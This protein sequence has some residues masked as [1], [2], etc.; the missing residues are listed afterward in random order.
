VRTDAAESELA[1]IESG[2]ERVNVLEEECERARNAYDEVAAQLARKRKAAAKKLV[3]ATETHLHDL[4]LGGAKLLVTLQTQEP[5][6]HGS[7]SVRML[8]AANRG[9]EAV[10]L[11]KGASGGELSRVNLALLLAGSTARGTWIFDEVDAGIGGATAHVVAAKLKALSAHTQVIVVTHLAQIAVQAD[12]HLVVRKDDEDGVAS[13]YVVAL[14]DEREHERE[15]ARLIGADADN[16]EAAKTAAQ[17]V[18]DA[19]SV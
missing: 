16:E 12:R 4:G 13:T 9:L 18:R 3:A 8:L 14:T 11:D 15:I 7:E 5:N 10:P 6:A 2:D 17:L 19:A 1:D